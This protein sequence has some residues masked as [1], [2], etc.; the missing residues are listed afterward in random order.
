MLN[1]I[2]VV[3]PS[4]LTFFIGIA[5]TPFFTDFFYKHKLWKKNPRTEAGDIT[6][7][8]FAKMPLN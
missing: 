8:D 2:K 4:V 7:D 5:I 6:S 1:V 3:L